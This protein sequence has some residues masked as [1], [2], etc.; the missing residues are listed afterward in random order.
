MREFVLS[1]VASLV[2]S[3]IFIGISF[4]ISSVNGIVLSIFVGCC[5]LFFSLYLLIAWK[6]SKNPYKH[7]HISGAK[8]GL[9]T[10]PDKVTCKG[11]SIL[12]P[13]YVRYVSDSGIHGY[14]HYSQ[15]IIYL[16]Y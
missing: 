16:G 8:A 14:V 13:N 11:V 9:T 3:A 10:S 2:A 7:I 12:R 4:M 1:I 15:I 5:F 6:H